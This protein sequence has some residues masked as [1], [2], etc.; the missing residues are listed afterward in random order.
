MNQSITVLIT[1]IGSP[2]APGVIKSL[3][4]VK[5][6]DF[7][8]IGIDINPYIAGKAMVDKFLVGPKATEPNF[9]HEILKLC[10]VEKVDV[11]LPLVSK[12]LISFSKYIHR[13][14]EVGTEV[15]ISNYETL[16]KTINKGKL[17]DTLEKVGIPVPRFEIV[18]TVDKLHEAL[19]KLGYPENPVC[20]KPTI[21]DG[22]RGF[23]I[24]DKQKNRMDLLYYEKPS[25][26]YIGFEE[27]FDTLQGCSIIPET[28]VMEYL[29]F[30]EYS[31]DILAKQGEVIIAI[32]RLREE[33]SN[34]ISVKGTIV[35][36]NDVIQ[37]TSR[38]V[39]ELQLHGNI[40]VQ[41]RKDKNHQ[42]KIIEINPRIQGTIVHCTKAGVNL[43]YLA[44]KL[45]KGLPITQDELIVQWG[46]QMA[47]YWEEVYF[48]KDGL[49][50]FG[51]NN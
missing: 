25:S 9:V 31:V 17:I 35:K 42:P 44:V 41:V 7:N 20:M 48:D 10:S 32:P 8:I 34:G 15:S 33:I 37:Y 47:R 38:I 43:P 39:K 11:V 27:L 5:E 13:F 3:K 6:Y 2:G 18:H 50:I 45:A 16:V 49:P 24:L 28:I 22:S 46:I 4:S 23:R 30:E 12:E 40:G 1:G 26:L 51:E 21:S 19:F 29:P 36:E 14:K